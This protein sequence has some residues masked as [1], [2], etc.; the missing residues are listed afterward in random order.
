MF[1]VFIK[2]GG[3]Q[4]NQSEFFSKCNAASGARFEVDVEE[5]RVS[6]LVE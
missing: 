2:D 6:L 3:E 5:L 4:K 1:S